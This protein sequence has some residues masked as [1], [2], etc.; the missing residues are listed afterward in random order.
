MRR[1]RPDG[2][3]RQPGEHEFGQCDQ[4]SGAVAAPAQADPGRQL[5][6]AEF[7]HFAIKS[8]GVW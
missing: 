4:V 7:G 2:G 3:E 1:V 6:Q 5:A 8:Q